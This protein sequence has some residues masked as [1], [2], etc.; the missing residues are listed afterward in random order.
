MEF[1]SIEE[2]RAE[3]RRENARR[4][5]TRHPDR[6]RAANRK[7][8]KKAYDRDPK[9]VIARNMMSR[10]ERY[11]KHRS[12]CLNH[13]G[14]KCE[15]CGETEGSFLGV[16]HINGGGR[17]HR[18]QLRKSGS[19]IYRFLVQNSFPDGY[20]L[21]CHNCNIAIGLYGSCPHERKI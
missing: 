6:A 4:Y 5:R 21:L 3:R 18:A 2:V 10:K 16:D 20:R 19:N 12:V 11:R 8:M 13:Y 17:D 9:K 1:I 7:S 15:C 14:H